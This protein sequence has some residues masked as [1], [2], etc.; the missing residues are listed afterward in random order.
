MKGTGRKLSA[1]IS[2][3]AAVLVATLFCFSV[4]GSSTALS[5]ASIRGDGKHLC[6][7]TWIAPDVVLTAAHCLNDP[8]ADNVWFVSGNWSSP[9]ATT[10]PQIF[11]F[12]TTQTH[13]R[14]YYHEYTGG[15]DVDPY[16]V[17]VIQI[18]G[19]VPELV[20]S[21]L[22]S[23]NMNRDPRIPRHPATPDDT[24]PLIG[25]TF[26]ESLATESQV[27]AN[28]SPTIDYW[29][30]ETTLFYIP[31]DECI[32]SNGIASNGMDISYTDQILDVSLCALY[33]TSSRKPGLCYGS[34]GGP[35]LV[36]T[37]STSGEHQL[38]QVGVISSSYGCE[39]ATLPTLN[40]RL[41]TV[42]AW[43]NAMICELSHYPS[44][45]LDCSSKLLSG[46]HNT[47][48]SNLFLTVLIQLDE[49]PTET[50]FLV[51]VETKDGHLERVYNR[52]PG[53]F[54]TALAGH[55]VEERV[56]LLSA[57]SLEPTRYRFTM[58]DNEHDGL[59]PP[60]HY[61]VWLGN[62]ASG[63]LLFEG[64]EFHLEDVHWFAIPGIGATGGDGDASITS[65]SYASLATT[66][67]P[68]LSFLFLFTLIKF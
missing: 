43:I 40:V 68:F 50:G 45:D 60:G 9:V 66:L 39:H 15:I 56:D 42:S 2:V 63:T 37:K 4:G 31:N 55:L 51:D 36:N 49:Y 21:S 53:S 59:D 23:S 14:Y 22:F 29:L 44:A 26:K 20:N 7:G 10:Q 34:S 33:D 61:Q 1:Q 52:Y 6:G 32:H 35:L 48:V 13:P 27:S 62:S 30:E 58:T 28:S 54:G 16:D 57:V 41:S 24:V 46:D 11:T 3:N 5:F 65:G 38:V 64:S 47:I 8:T 17:A 25:L 67:A 19:H 18:D 12:K